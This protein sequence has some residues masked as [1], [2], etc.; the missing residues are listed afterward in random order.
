MELL[1]EGFANAL[2][3][4]NLLYAVI[5]VLL[6]TAV[7]VL[8][9]IGPAMTVALLLPITYNVEPAGALIMFAG[10]YYGGMY[11]GST[12]SILLNTPGESSSVVTALEG[13]K[14]AKRGRAAQALATAAIGSFVAGTIGSILLV[15]LMPRIAD[16][17]VELGAPSY[18]AIML[19]ALFTVTAVLGS[20][21]LRG[22]TSL[23]LGLTIALVGSQTGQARLT[24]G[25]PELA[26]GIDVV[27]VAVAIFAIGEALWVAAH[28]RRRPLEIIPVGQPWMSRADWGRS[29]KPWLRGTA[30]GFPFGA[31]PAGGAEVPTFLSYITER[32][33][34]KHP[35]E[36]GQG[37]IEGVAGPEAANNASA[38]GTLVPLLA[39]GLPTTATAAV[40]LLAIQSYGIQPGPQLMDAEP[41]LVW[42]LLASL[43]IA[44]VLLL[45]LN[46]PM[47]P[48][49]A[50]LLQIPRPYLYA[51]ILFF[52]ALGAYSVNFQA[53]DLGILL[54]LGLLGFAMRRFGLPVLPLIIGVIL[55][56][57]LEEQLTTALAI[58]Q[59]DLSTLWSEPV[60]VLVYVLMAA[61]AV[62]MGV[63]A[64]RRRGHDTDEIDRM[65][66]RAAVT[67]RD[68]I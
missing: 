35:E 40:M 61:I 1:L 50:K 44:N 33:L 55:G 21:K 51:G 43:F 12:T 62:V 31:L 53:F 2:T 34:T 28:L 8:P 60:A 48:I 4:E 26:D 66:D 67:D 22:F 59:G 29:W 68:D 19:F 39:I 10:I 14:M 3:P 58:S 15:V 24:F 45:V 5:G 47:A 65:L 13:N 32:R 54:V 57:R 37:A 25:R 38:A 64:W 6:G 23:F 42:A 46:L 49:W 41:E 17:V 16:V 63:V 56:P 30:Y 52:A 20:S 9:G 7:G 36:F 27:V 11:G 18:F